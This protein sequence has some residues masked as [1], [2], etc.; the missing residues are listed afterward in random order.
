MNLRKKIMSALIVSYILAFWSL[1]GQNWYQKFL[2]SQGRTMGLNEVAFGYL[3][4]FMFSWI[5][6]KILLGG[7]GEDG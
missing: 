1:Y 5:I 7:S 2:E 3:I 4:L 6:V